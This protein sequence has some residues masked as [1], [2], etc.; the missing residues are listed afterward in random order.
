VK[1]AV[2][3]ILLLPI[4]L[5]LLGGIGCQH[6][7]SP[8]LPVT[9]ASAA[10][11]EQP[12]ST[13]QNETMRLDWMELNIPLGPEEDFQPWMLSTRIKSLDGQQVRITGYMHPG[14]AQKDHIR[15]FVLIKHV[16]CEFG[17]EGQPQHVIL[18]EL[19]GKLRTTLTTGAVTVEGRFAVNPFTGADGR[20]WALYRLAANQ[21]KQDE[22]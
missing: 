6:E 15:E 1:P 14:V 16:G 17:V 19:G 7:S 21:I 10:A 8:P 20:T 9:A 11:A 22:P 18:V 3:L 13:S 5:G 2:S 12:V 4:A